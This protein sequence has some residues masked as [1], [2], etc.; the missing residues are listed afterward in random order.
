MAKRKYRNQSE[1]QE[2]IREYNNNHKAESKSSFCRERKLSIT[3]FCKWHKK[4]NGEDKFIKIDLK[5]KT[6][7]LKMFGIKLIGFEL[8][9]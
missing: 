7:Y 8:N 1:W 3:T 2:I 4:F 6:G 5:P 9:V